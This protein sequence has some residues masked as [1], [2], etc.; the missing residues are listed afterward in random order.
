[1]WCD[2]TD[3]LPNFILL[4]KNTE[5]R[6]ETNNLPF[7]RLYFPKNIKKFNELISNVNW[8]SLYKCSNVDKAY[9]LFHKKIT[10][11]DDKGF[12]KV[13]SSR[14]RA[15]DE[16]WV[17]Q[18]IKRSSNHKNKLFKKW[19]C[20]HS[21]DD[22]QKYKDYEEIFKKVTLAAQTAYYKEQEAQLSQTGRAMPRVV[23]Y[24]G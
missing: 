1:L 10:D 2:I 20:S 23:E 7:V 6:F 19:I 18:G 4:K 5:R 21:A 12:P 8:D 17:T 9:G 22:Q 24:F 13:R 14:K 16:L 3:H 11:C 15:K